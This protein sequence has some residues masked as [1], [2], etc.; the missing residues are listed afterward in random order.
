MLLAMCI[1]FL[2]FHLLVHICFPRLQEAEHDEAE[3]E[4]PLVEGWNSAAA[5]D[6]FKAYQEMMAR[7]VKW[8]MMLPHLLR[9]YL[10]CMSA[11]TQ[12]IAPRSRRARR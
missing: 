1:Q 9:V 6:A 11:S 10:L 12:C 5:T 2:H 7:Q 3:E 4:M 8:W